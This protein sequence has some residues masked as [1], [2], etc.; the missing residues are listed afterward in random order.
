MYKEGD[1][2]TISLRTCVKNKVKEAQAI[3]DYNFA[4]KF[5]NHLLK[6]GKMS[7][8]NQKCTDQTL[9]EAMV[10]NYCQMYRQG[11]LE[12]QTKMDMIESFFEKTFWDQAIEYYKKKD[13]DQWQKLKLKI[14][15]TRIIP[16]EYY[17]RHSLP[18]P[19]DRTMRPNI[20]C[21]MKENDV[22]E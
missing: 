4:V 15:A 10:R 22:N 8:Q 13:P 6:E 16:V 17:Y 2:V 1:Y 11:G 20:M 12:N 21:V 7:T 19:E 5:W 3:R 9:W 18:I 14:R